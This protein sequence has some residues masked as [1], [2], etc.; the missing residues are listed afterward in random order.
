[1]TKHF[2]QLSLVRVS[3]ADILFLWLVGIFVHGYFWCYIWTLAALTLRLMRT[4]CGWGHLEPRVTSAEKLLKKEPI[5]K[6]I[7]KKR[8]RCRLTWKPSIFI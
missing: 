5:M 4:N 7:M 8:K 3:M 6:K 1:M 2:P